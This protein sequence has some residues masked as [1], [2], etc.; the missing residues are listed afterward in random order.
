MFEWHSALAGPLRAGGRDGARGARR[1][2]LTEVRGWHLAQLAAFPD[3]HGELQQ[4]LGECGALLPV[5][6]YQGVTLGHSRFVRIAQHQYWWIAS[7]SASMAR[8]ARELPASAGT[9][10]VLSAGRVR[11]RI[12]GPA[13]RDVLAQGISLDLHPAAFQ[14]GRSAQTG[15]HHT[16]VFLERVG[17]DGYEIYVQRSYAEWIWEWLIDA[18]LPFGYDVGVEE[19][20]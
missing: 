9:V 14:V 17:D 7:G 5:E 8:L 1:L 11:I 19:A 2:R 4:H 20:A 18:A 12:T 16:G 15:L 13:A 6:L 3:H 10:T